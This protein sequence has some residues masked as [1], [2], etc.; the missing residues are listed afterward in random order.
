VSLLLCACAF[1]C[2]AG[3]N[4]TDLTPPPTVVFA[5]FDPAAMPP[6][7]PLPNDLTGIAAPTTSP[8]FAAFS[9]PLDPATIRA[10]DVLVIDLVTMM[11]ATGA[12][13]VFDASS[14]RLVIMPPPAGW[15][16]GHRIAVVLLGGANGLKGPG[17]EPVVA[18]PTF[19]FATSTKPFSNCTTPAP[20]C[21]SASPF[22]PVDQAIGLERLRLAFAPLFTALA[23]KGIAISDVVLAWTF[24]I[25]PSM[26]PAQ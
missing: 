19:F 8:A 23:A 22:I 9:G 10:D 18:S 14:N 24:T 4:D 2:A 7:L 16:A 26:P 5:L 1:A 3:C 13:A 17:G 21:T 6:V 20:N 11:P 12:T 15:P 25:L